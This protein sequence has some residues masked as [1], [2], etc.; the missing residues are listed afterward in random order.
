MFRVGFDIY[1]QCTKCP[2][3]SFFSLR[4]EYVNLFVILEIPILIMPFPA[5]AKFF[6]LYNVNNCWTV[7]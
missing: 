5:H 3:F 1:E 4:F 2:G 7:Y 6:P